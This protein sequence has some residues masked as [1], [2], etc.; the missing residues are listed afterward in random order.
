MRVREADPGEVAAVRNVLDG[1]ALAVDHDLLRECLDQ[2]A[3]LVATS[4][5]SSSDDTAETDATVLGALVLDGD[6]I[7]AVA[8][9]RNRRG[10]G[11]GTELVEAAAA[12]RDRLVAE[13]DA[14]VRPFY[15]RLGFDVEPTADPDRY[16]GLWTPER[17]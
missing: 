7:D 4:T 3:V 9:R 16:R 13:F 5:D 11:I 15:E 17:P 1:A 6:R 8:V 2:G 14:G 10:Q 12:R